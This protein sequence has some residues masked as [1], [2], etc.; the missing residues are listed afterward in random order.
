MLWAE[1]IDGQRLAR[2]CLMLPL[3]FLCLGTV[4]SLITMLGFH[5]DFHGGHTSHPEAIRMTGQAHLIMFANMVIE[6][7]IVR[8]PKQTHRAEVGIYPTTRQL[9]L[10]PAQGVATVEIP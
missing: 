5:V 1:S 4:F 9:H 3:L 8:R 10:H 2:H 6:G 7:F